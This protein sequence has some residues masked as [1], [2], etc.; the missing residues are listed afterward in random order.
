MTYTPVNN[1]PQI[2][3]RVVYPH[4]I[5]RPVQGEPSMTKPSPTEAA[6]SWLN[7]HAQ[8]PPQAGVL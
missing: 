8:V 1:P 5:V 4:E 3:E 6:A 7:F 2:P